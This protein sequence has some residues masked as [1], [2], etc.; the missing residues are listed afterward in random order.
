[1]YMVNHKETLR[2]SIYSEWIIDR[3]SGVTLEI[4]KLMQKYIERRLEEQND[5][6]H[7]ENKS[8]MSDVNPTISVI[9]L[10]VNGL[11]NSIKRRRFKY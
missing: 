9:T 2:K 10:N 1:M 11:N 5:M 4:V 3:N 8:K 6:G 7:T